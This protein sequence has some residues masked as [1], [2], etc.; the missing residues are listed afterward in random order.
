MSETLPVTEQSLYFSCG[1]GEMIS[2]LGKCDGRRDCISGLDEEGCDTS[3][4]ATVE[5]QWLEHL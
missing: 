5:R 1:D 2:V 3:G 4:K